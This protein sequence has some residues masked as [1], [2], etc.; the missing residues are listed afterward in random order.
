M[1][2]QLKLAIGIL[3]AFIILFA[4]VSAGCNSKNRYAP[5]EDDGVILV[6]QDRDDFNNNEWENEDRYPVYDYRW[7]Y[8]YRTSNDY[9]E[10]RIL[11]LQEGDRNNW[12]DNYRNF[13]RN[14]YDDYDYD[15]YYQEKPTEK[16]IYVDYLRSYQKIECYNYPPR[17]KLVYVKC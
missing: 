7:G 3:F 12:N 11:R 4:N 13:E 2:N 14:G 9:Q 5:G 8:S 16:Y 6:I 10:D 1:K 17:D 15:F